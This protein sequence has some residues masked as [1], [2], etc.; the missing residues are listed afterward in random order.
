VTAT[1]RTTTSKP[2]SGDPQATRPY[3]TLPSTTWPVGVYFYSYS[4]SNIG[5]SHCAVVCLSYGSSLRISCRVDLL[6]PAGSLI[7]GINV[8][9]HFGVMIWRLP[10]VIIELMNVL[11]APISVLKN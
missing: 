4:F 11:N 2:S 1:R 3:T 5:G 6:R 9:K 8:P 7:N 10:S